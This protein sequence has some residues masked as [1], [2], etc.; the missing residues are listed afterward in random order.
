ML[1]TAFILFGALLIIGG[2]WITISSR[3]DIALAWQS[4]SWP[5]VTGRIIEKRVHEGL[6]TGMSSDGTYAPVTQRWVDVELVFAY[7]VAGIDYTSTRFDF[8]GF[9]QRFNSHYYEDDAKVYVYYCPTNPS[10]SVLRT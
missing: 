6:C 3:Q 9:G 1:F 4:R 7:S 10:I 8:S 2:L 5:H